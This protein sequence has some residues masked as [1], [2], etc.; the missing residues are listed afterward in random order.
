LGGTKL[1]IRFGLLGLLISHL[2]AVG[3]LGLNLIERHSRVETEYLTAR[4]VSRGF[5]LTFWHKADEWKEKELAA[6]VDISAMDERE[7]LDWGNLAID[8]LIGIFLVALG[9]VLSTIAKNAVGG[10]GGRG[11]TATLLT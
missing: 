5:P 9:A 7:H 11:L 2:I 3:W 8:V 4:I 10:K 1:R 6:I